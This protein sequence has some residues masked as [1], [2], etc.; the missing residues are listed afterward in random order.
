MTRRILPISEPGLSEAFRGVQPRIRVTAE[1]GA[2]S[3]GQD[4]AVVAVVA[5]IGEDGEPELRQVMQVA[6]TPSVWAGSGCLRVQHAAPGTSRRLP[7]LFSRH[8][9]K[10]MS[11]NPEILA[12][13]TA[14][15]F[16]VVAI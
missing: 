5:P 8:D 12:Q 2:S 6:A 16:G 15:D 1:V 4:V 10:H 9:G 11:T 3:T 14:L 13:E 7:V